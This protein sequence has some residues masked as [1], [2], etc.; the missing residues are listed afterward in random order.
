MLMK[1]SNRRRS[2]TLL[3]DFLGTASLNLS[4]GMVDN[5]QVDG[6]TLLNQRE[7]KTILR[8]GPGPLK[9]TKQTVQTSGPLST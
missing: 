2:F 9:Q 1:I 6:R 8:F 5:K 7:D 3:P 4:G